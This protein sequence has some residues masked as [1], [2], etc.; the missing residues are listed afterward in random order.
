MLGI[1]TIR[2]YFFEKILASGCIWLFGKKPFTSLFILANTLVIYM[3][4]YLVKIYYIYRYVIYTNIIG[5]LTK[6]L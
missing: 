3:Y 4:L 1:K 5:I 6:T 2:K